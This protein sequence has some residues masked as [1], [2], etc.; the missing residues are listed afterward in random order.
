MR[1]PAPASSALTRD[2]NSNWLSLVNFTFV[3]DRDRQASVLDHPTF[4]VRQIWKVLDEN[5]IDVSHLI[6][7]TYDYHSE[8]ELRWHL[9]ERFASPVRSVGLNRL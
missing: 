8:R 3:C 2:L 7:R 9:A 5:R 1:V 6:D 4:Q